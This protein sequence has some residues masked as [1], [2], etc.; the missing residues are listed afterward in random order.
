MRFFCCEVCVVC[1]MSIYFLL[2]P[3]CL[4]RHSNSYLERNNFFFMAF[5]SQLTEQ[6]NAYYFGRFVCTS[7]KHFLP[8]VLCSIATYAKSTRFGVKL[9]GYIIYSHATIMADAISQFRPETAPILF[10][11]TRVQ[12]HIHILILI[13]ILILLLARFLFYH[14]QYVVIIYFK[15][16]HFPNV[17]LIYIESHF[18]FI[19]LRENKFV[20]FIENTNC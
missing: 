20:A 6:Q 1:R 9:V 17:R 8:F 14:S 4:A 5:F 18:V 11:L 15:T 3:R 19:L 13:L 16:L 12:H 10:F 7:T 2:L